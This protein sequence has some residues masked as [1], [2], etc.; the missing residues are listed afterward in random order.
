MFRRGWGM[1][2]IL[3]FRGRDTGNLERSAKAPA[4]SS[5]GDE[6][7]SRLR[8]RSRRHASRSYAAGKW[9]V[10]IS[11]G[12][13]CVSIVARICYYLI[14]QETLTTDKAVVE[15]Y[16]YPVS[17]KIDGT[18][19]GVFVSNRQYVKA[20]DLLAEMDKKDLEGKLAAWREDLAQERT[21]LPQLEIQ[22]SKAQA[23]L[24]K[25]TAKMRRCEKELAE[26]T[27]DFQY[28]SKIRNK[29]GVSPLLFERTKKAYDVALGEYDAAKTTFVGVNDLVRQAQTLRNAC[30]TKLHNAE[31]QM[32]HMEKQLLYTKIYAPANGH[33]VFEK[34]NF[35]RRL[36]AGE[37][38]LKLIG[39]DPWVVANFNENQLKHIKPGQ[40]V[41][42]RIEAIKEHTFRGEVVSVASVGN[43]NSRRIALLLS[44]FA[45]ID[46]PQNLPV[47][48]T[49]DSESELGFAEHLDP[50]LNAYVEIDTKSRRD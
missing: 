49:F 18:I 13:I 17:S 29:K 41:K 33:V 38:F 43:G 31:T 7:R 46:P 40:R 26:T 42:I 25:A 21:K 47:K 23:E 6:S 30:L 3:R 24:E 20:G 22:R 44:L 11:A 19:G 35:A 4:K 27:S 1:F 50:D 48:V 16:T 5:P 2:S 10:L 39:D 36:T 9:L 28:I 8:A 32:Q 45:L 12:I 37:P 34:P 14:G 15:A